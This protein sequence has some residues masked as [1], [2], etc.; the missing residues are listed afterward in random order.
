MTRRPRGQAGFTLLEVILA[1]V[2]LAMLTGIVYGAF[3]LGTRAV[4]KGQAAVV[5]SQRVRIA[6]DVLSRQIKSMVPYPARN[7]DDDRYYYFDVRPGSISFVT[8]AGLQGGGGLVK[9]T[10]R[11]NESPP[12]L[13]ITEN[14][15]IS[16][17]AL[18]NERVVDAGARTAVLLDG[19]RSMRF[20]YWDPDEKGGYDARWDQLERQSLPAAIRIT[21][22]GLPGFDDAP[23]VEEIPVQSFEYSLNHDPDGFMNEE[24]ETVPGVGGAPGG[25]GATNTSDTGD[26]GDDGDEDDLDDEDEDF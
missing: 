26:D 10:Y 4:E 25:S 14:P 8:A 22:E 9:V 20:E 13:L 6:S 12:Q 5:T 11:V 3:H 19:F 18:G 24:A 21:I 15:F 16:P 7:D 23:L 17:D 1:M 2:S